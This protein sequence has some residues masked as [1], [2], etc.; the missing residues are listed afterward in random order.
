MNST[1]K[2]SNSPNCRHWQEKTHIGLEVHHEIA[3]FSVCRAI[4]HEIPLR[5]PLAHRSLTTALNNFIW[6]AL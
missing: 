5:A 2:S 1:Y 4:S 3:G 6:R